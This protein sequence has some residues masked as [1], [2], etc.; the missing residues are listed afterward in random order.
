[1]HLSPDNG[2]T[3]IGPTRRASSKVTYEVVTRHRPIGT[4][5]KVARSS[6]GAARWRG[7]AL[8]RAP[9]RALRARSQ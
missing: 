8:P 1:V 9:R 5:H 7:F 2:S 3:W 6:Y 4:S